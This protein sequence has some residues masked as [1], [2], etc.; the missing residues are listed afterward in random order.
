[1]VQE[2][3]VRKE[4]LFADNERWIMNYQIDRHGDQVFL[5][6]VSTINPSLVS[7]AEIERQISRGI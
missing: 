7:D 3:I 4:S 5:N 1:M 6:V 2:M